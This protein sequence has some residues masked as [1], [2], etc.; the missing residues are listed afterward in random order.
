M[1]PVSTST[2][3]SRGSL[4][5]DP[6]LLR[7]HRIAVVHRMVEDARRM[8][9]SGVWLALEEIEAVLSV[10]AEGSPVC[11]GASPEST[12]DWIGAVCT[13]LQTWKGEHEMSK[14]GTPPCHTDE[15]YLAYNPSA[16]DDF[17]APVEARKTRIVI[18]QKEHLCMGHLCRAQKIIPVGSRVFRESGKCEGVFSTCYVCLPCID[19]ALE[20]DYW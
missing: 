17:P 10:E 5:S 9:R 16:G 15:Q 1:S 6:R 4:F 8:Q 20:P 11:G 3:G 12:R 13:R 7:Q 19:F 2:A 18:T 14:T